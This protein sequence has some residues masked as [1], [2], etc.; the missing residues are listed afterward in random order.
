MDKAKKKESSSNAIIQNCPNIKSWSNIKEVWLKEART[1][2]AYRGQFPGV[3][4]K[5]AYY[6]A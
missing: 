5:R 6:P 1:S 2:S 3:A 4:K